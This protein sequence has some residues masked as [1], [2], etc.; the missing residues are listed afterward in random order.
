MEHSYLTVIRRKR[1]TKAYTCPKCGKKA[2]QN[3]LT[4]A[5]FS[6]PPAL[7]VD[8]KCRRCEQRWTVAYEVARAFTVPDRDYF[9][10]EREELEV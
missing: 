8:M 1:A 5:D 9:L 2:R 6:C 10:E 3:V 7:F 4:T